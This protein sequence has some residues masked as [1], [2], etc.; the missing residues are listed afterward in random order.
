M[1]QIELQ[2]AEKQFMKL[3]EMAA[4]GEEIII[5]KNERP[6]VKLLP[7]T[8]SIQKREFGSAKGLIQM[9]DDFDEPLADFEEYM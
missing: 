1:T 3:V 4:N 2:E 8:P 9:A 7:I 6:F 5:Y